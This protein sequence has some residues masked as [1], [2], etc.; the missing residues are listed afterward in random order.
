MASLIFWISFLFFLV[1]TV[2]AE[3]GQVQKESVIK[4]MLLRD[5]QPVVFY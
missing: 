4:F 3:G 1:I 2:A 5:V